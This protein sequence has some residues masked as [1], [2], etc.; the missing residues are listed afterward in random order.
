MVNSIPPPLLVPPL[1]DPNPVEGSEEWHTQQENKTKRKNFGATIG[2]ASDQKIR[3]FI[4]EMTFKSKI[5]E[6]TTVINL[7]NPH[8]T[9]IS[10]L[11]VLTTGDAH[12]MPTLRINDEDKDGLP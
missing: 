11:F 9:F 2:F 5:D 3:S 7:F 4:F 1:K 8:K 12:V 10:Q 6:A